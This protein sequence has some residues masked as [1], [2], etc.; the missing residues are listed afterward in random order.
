MRH[1]WEAV[2]KNCGHAVYWQITSTPSRWEHHTRKYKPYGFPYS[3]IKCYAGNC[4]CENPEPKCPN[5]K[6]ENFIKVDYDLGQARQIGWHCSKCESLTSD[7]RVIQ[8]L[9]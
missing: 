2:C 1:P 9:S 6:N 4:E 7:D 8:T 5:C 3:T